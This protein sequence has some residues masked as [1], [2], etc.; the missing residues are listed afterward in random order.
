MAKII[1]VKKGN[2]PTAPQPCPYVID[3]PMELRK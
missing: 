1:I 2:T 3:W